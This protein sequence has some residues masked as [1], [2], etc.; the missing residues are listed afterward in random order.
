MGNKQAV[1]SGVE[2]Q[3][4]DGFGGDKAMGGAVEAIAS[5]LMLV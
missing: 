4:R 5:D 2:T 1:V 3:A